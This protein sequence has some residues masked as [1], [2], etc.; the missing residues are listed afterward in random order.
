MQSSELD[1]AIKKSETLQL[2][3][4]QLKRQYHSDLQQL[5]REVLHKGSQNEE[6]QSEMLQKLKQNETIV[7]QS[8]NFLKEIAGE[9]SRLP[10][11]DTRFTVY[12]TRKIEMFLKLLEQNVVSQQKQLKSPAS[13][14]S[15]TPTSRERVVVGAFKSAS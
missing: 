14:H 11:N 6:K 3:I 1:M 12:L 4:V 5:Q 9:A 7:Q 2:A 10:Q 15:E 8:A 13:N